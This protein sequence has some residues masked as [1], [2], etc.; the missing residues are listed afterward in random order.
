MRR[1]YFHYNKPASAS[2]GKIQMSV[3]FK[4][5]C[6]VVDHVICKVSC[7][8]HHQKR[9]PHCVMRGFANNVTVE[10]VNNMT[11]ATIQ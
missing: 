4:D 3:H 9:Q 6:Y 5:T 2:A 7:D 11:Y 10:Q 1:F 8:S